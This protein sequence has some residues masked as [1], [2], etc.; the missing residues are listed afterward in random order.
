MFGKELKTIITG[1]MMM[2]LFEQFFECSATWVSV[3]LPPLNL[4]HFCILSSQSCTNNWTNTEKV[5]Y[6]LKNGLISNPFHGYG[7]ESHS[8]CESLM[9]SV[10]CI[11]IIYIYVYSVAS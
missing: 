1:Q 11:Y 6:C 9:Y 5:L 8:L 7:K 10:A 2:M 3:L 4:V